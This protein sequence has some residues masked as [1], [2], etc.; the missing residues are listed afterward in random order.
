[1]SSIIK[2]ENLRKKYLLEGTYIEA[3]KGITL[4]IRKG[5]MIAL[6]GPSGSG[7]STLLHIL[8]GIDIPTEGKVFIMEQNIFS[9]SEKKLARFRNVNIGFVFQFHYLL[10]EFTALENVMIPVQ[11]YNKKGAR[12]KAE[13]ILVKLGL[14]D[15]LN[16][17][18]S[19]MSGGEQQRVAIARAVV[20]NP[21]VLLADEPTGNLD[22]A[23]TQVVMELLKELNKKNNVTMVIATHD[24]EVAEYC[25]RII[26]LR[27][28][29][30]QG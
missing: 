7:K 28:G 30:L 8:G 29:I 27:D 12:E 24:R 25:D 14:K 26:F 4:N 13:K 17:K 22:T 16:H 1:M 3:L 19:Q 9:L 6:M 23:N 10:P 18:P 2:T 11:I 21:S 20:N 5:E 15:R